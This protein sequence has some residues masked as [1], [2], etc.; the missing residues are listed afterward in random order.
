MGGRSWMGVASFRRVGGI[1]LG[2]LAPVDVVVRGVGVWRCG[3][4]P[5]EQELAGGVVSGR[6][7]VDGS[8]WRSCIFR[9]RVIPGRFI[10]GR[11]TPGRSLARLFLDRFFLGRFFLGRFFLVRF[12][13][14][15]FFLDRFFLDRFFLG[16]LF[17]GWLFL[18]RLRGGCFRGFSGHCDGLGGPWS[19]PGFAFVFAS[20]VASAHADLVLGVVF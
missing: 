12:F 3:G 17:L 15:R 14:G 13:L 4:C 18:G 16:R 20:V 11:F 6:D 5:G 8:C 19:A 9:G 2:A 10:P 1:V 7:G